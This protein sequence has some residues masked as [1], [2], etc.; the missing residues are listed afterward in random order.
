MIPIDLTANAAR[1]ASSS[2]F[3]KMM[4]KSFL[5]LSFAAIPVV[6]PLWAPSGGFVPGRTQ[7]GQVPLPQLTPQQWKTLLRQQGADQKRLHIDV[8]LSIDCGRVTDV[9]VRSGGDYPEIDSA[10]GN[11]IAANW[12]LAPWFRGGEHYI[13]LLDVDPA[14]RRVVF[15]NS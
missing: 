12:K 8:D 2:L 15:R 13:V 1:P 3:S 6:A 11:W 14:L 5:T 4:R 7:V 9:T 10:I